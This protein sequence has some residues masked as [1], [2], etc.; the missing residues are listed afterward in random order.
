VHASTGCGAEGYFAVQGIINSKITQLEIK[1]VHYEAF[2]DGKK[3]SDWAFSHTLFF[4]G[5]YPIS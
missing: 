2:S 5:P 4:L 1:E 3:K